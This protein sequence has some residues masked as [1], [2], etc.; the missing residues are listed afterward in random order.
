MSAPDTDA[1]VRLLELRPQAQQDLLLD[2]DQTYSFA[3]LAAF[4]KRHGLGDESEQ[5]LSRWFVEASSA[6]ARDLNARPLGHVNAAA[7]VLDGVGVGGHTIVWA[8][9]ITMDGAEIPLGYVL[10]RKRR[11]SLVETKESVCELLRNLRDRGL[12]Y[13]DALFVIDGGRGLRS[14]ILEMTNGRAMIQR[15]V[16]HKNRNV[17][18]Q[19]LP[20]AE[21][22]RIGKQV[23]ARLKRAWDEPDRDRAAAQLEELAR[24]LDSKGLTASAASIHE[25]IEM[26]LTLKELEADESL[27][28]AFYTNNRIERAHSRIARWTKLHVTYWQ[29]IRRADDPEP[30]MRE[31][32]FASAVAV[33]ELTW[34]GVAVE[35]HLF[36]DMQLA[37]MKRRN[38]AVELE[39]TN[40]SGHLT[41]T[42]LALSP[43][44]Q[45]QTYTAMTELLRWADRNGKAV[46]IT[47]GALDHSTGGARLRQWLAKRGF[48]PGWPAGMERHDALVRAPRQPNTPSRRHA[49]RP[50]QAPAPAR[51]EADH[52]DHRAAQAVYGATDPLAELR[53][54]VSAELLTKIGEVAL[55]ASPRMVAEPSAAL[56]AEAGRLETIRRATTTLDARVREWV[57]AHSDNLARAVALAEERASRG[58]PETHLLGEDRRRVLGREFTQWVVTRASFFRGSIGDADID[59]LQA[60]EPDLAPA[61]AE[62][63]RLADDLQQAGT[64]VAAIREQSRRQLIS[65][66]TQR[67]TADPARGSDTSTER[68]V[69]RPVDRLERNARILGSRRGM[70]EV[71]AAA[72]EP[73]LANLDSATLLALRDEVG[74]AWKHLGGASALRTVNLEA[75]EA[76]ALEQCRA[77]LADHAWWLLQ[78]EKARSPRLRE[79]AAAESG[80][81]IRAAR[82]HWTELRTIDRALRKERGGDRGLEHFIAAHPDAALHVAIDRV[83]ARHIGAARP[84]PAVAAQRTAAPAPEAAI[85]Y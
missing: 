49:R 73:E 12:D 10:D 7:I 53:G 44:R 46:E 68:R 13:S 64:V 72:L 82:E 16:V 38:S 52:R 15:C 27:W 76:K 40:A 78:A 20:A 32:W 31:R 2:I 25:G 51:R 79:S 19:N 37:G 26:T 11:K 35:R 23:R 47:A 81:C 77:S 83:L 33:A 5:T 45:R 3:A 80:I 54:A 62:L 65:D 28:H 67:V 22:K 29:P 61:L 18:W 69:V 30:D 50:P 84:P 75:R 70:L 60:G 58:R 63:D 34:S 6:V 85:G 17:A 14:G 36:E 4:R 41:L 55:A 39:L 43:E 48:E 24:W 9:A 21:R 74:D 59:K 71:Y 66:V 8:Q 1:A 57:S 56:I 42:R